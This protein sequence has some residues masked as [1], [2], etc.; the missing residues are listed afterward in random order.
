MSNIVAFESAKLPAFL[1]KAA[2]QVNDDLTANVGAGFPVLSIKGKNWTVKR[3]GEATLLTRELDGEKIAAPHVEVVI[4]KANKAFSKTFYIKQFVEGTDAKPDCYS[5]DGVVP[6]ADAQSPQAKT[7]ATCPKNEWGS[8]I[9]DSGAKGKAC[10]DVRRLAV[11]A[12]GQ[13]NDPMLLRVPPATL[14]PLAE[15]AKMLSKRNIPYNAVVTKM[16]FD[17]EAATPKIEFSPVRFLTEAEYAEVE[18]IMQ[19]SLIEDIIG[20]TGT[21]MHVESEEG[22]AIAGENPAAKKHSKT[23]VVDEEP[24]PA[25]KAKAKPAVTEEEVAEVVEE[26]PAPK[27]KAKPAPVEAD[28]EPAPTPKKAAKVVEVAVDDELDSLLGELDD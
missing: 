14:K 17:S 23:V 5:N 25:P 3:G 7:C 11:A 10:Q 1:A 9:S 15:Y 13:I 24:A 21:P 12:A 8:K 6:A 19:D 26:A 18:E 4:L 28:E 2:P 20:T 16:K 22:P 27:A